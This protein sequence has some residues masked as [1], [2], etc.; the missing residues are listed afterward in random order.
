[1]D[2]VGISKVVE[3]LDRLAGLYGARFA[4]TRQLRDMAE[5]GATFHHE[6]KTANAA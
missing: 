4:P 3:T 5:S 2:T 6:A 1:M